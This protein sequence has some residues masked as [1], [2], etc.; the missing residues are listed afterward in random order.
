ML[1]TYGEDKYWRTLADVRLLDG[2]HVNQ[3]LVKEGWCWR[4]RKYAPGDQ[5]LEGLEHEAREARKGLW[6]KLAPCR[7]GSGGGDRGRTKGYETFDS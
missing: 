7:R 2:T 4:D 3:T 6:P 1:Q 5:V